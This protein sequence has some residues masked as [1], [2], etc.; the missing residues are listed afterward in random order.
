M[1]ILNFLKSLWEALT[2]KQKK[3]A[4]ISYEI[5]ESIKKVDSSHDS[6]L[7]VV[8]Q[9]IPDRLKEKFTDN[10]V[11]ILHNAGLIK[12]QK[13]TPDEAIAEAADFINK[14]KGSLN[15][16]VGLNNLGIFLASV[17]ADG[18]IQWNDLVHLPKLFYDNK[19]SS[20]SLLSGNDTDGDGIDDWEDDDADGDGLDYL[21]DPND[22][23][24]G[25]P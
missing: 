19:T 2:G 3:I 16:K 7:E 18:K 13:L 11:S 1:S 25:R 22:P 21:T 4:N 15:H 23:R 24:H 9:V 10:V 20:E 5:I 8:L 6:P 14:I 12:T 17:L